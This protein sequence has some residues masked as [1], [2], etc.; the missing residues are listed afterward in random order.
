M[1]DAL[2]LREDG[3]YRP[4][5]LA[6][7]PWTRGTLHGG[8]PSG[9]LAYGIEQAAGSGLQPARMTVDLLRPVPA[10]PL[11][12][13]TSLVRSGRRL[14]LVDAVLLAD[15]RPVCRASGLLLRAA[16]VRPPPFAAPPGSRPE[17]P[18]GVAGGRFVDPDRMPPGVRVL[19]GFHTSVEARRVSGRPGEG[20]GTV[21]MR[22][23][24][25]VVAGEPL[26]PLLRVASLADFGNGVG[27]IDVDGETGCINA[28]LTLYLH[29]LPVGEWIGIEARGMLERDGLGLAHTRLYDRQ[30]PIGY[31]TQALM[32]MPRYAG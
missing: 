16:A 6:G 1:T 10:Q 28:D 5:A 14:Q 7:G 27:Q 24:M 9:L 8:P 19:P 21:W 20:R 15:G 12:L 3:R 32:T 13:E 29:R 23:P 4:T 22:L 25:A 11:E 30:G 2:F 26:T 31:V 18:D 17:G